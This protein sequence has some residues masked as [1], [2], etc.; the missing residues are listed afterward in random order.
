M[1]PCAVATVSGG[2]RPIS[3]AAAAATTAPAAAAA[4]TFELQ[5]LP[6]AAA[7]APRAT[8]AALAL[9]QEAEAKR[10]ADRPGAPP[11]A[12]ADLALAIGAP[13]WTEV[14]GKMPRDEAAKYLKFHGEFVRSVAGLLK[15]YDAMPRDGE[16]AAVAALRP[17]LENLRQGLPTWLAALPVAQQAFDEKHNA[18]GKVQ[19]GAAAMA[20]CGLGIGAWYLGAPAITVGYAVSAGVLQ[21]TGYFLESPI[22]MGVGTKFSLAIAW[23]LP[24][25][26]SMG[27]WGRYGVSLGIAAVGAY[28][29]WTYALSAAKEHGS[30]AGVLAAGEASVLALLSLY[31]HLTQK[32]LEAIQIGGLV[33]TLS[34]A[35]M[36]NIPELLHD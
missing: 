5:K 35:I 33:V 9:P 4:P 22:L 30:T 20:C 26:L 10:P 29:G 14:M 19:A 2:A 12:P 1:T 6:A 34:G 16:P 13:S 17:Q 36:V 21:T 31:T 28:P 11:A 23:L 25:T 15:Q 7:A 3:P 8:G 18:W 32:H 24:P 27:F